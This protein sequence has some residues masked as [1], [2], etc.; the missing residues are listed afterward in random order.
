MIVKTDA[1]EKKGW[2]VVCK[3]P[4]TSKSTTVLSARGVNNLPSLLIY[5]MSE[6][7]LTADK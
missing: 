3:Q 5:I 2:R 6:M 1:L 7:P 4:T